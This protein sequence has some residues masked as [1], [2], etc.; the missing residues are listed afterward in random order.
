MQIHPAFQKIIRI[1]EI[2][3]T[4][5]L[6]TECRFQEQRKERY[7]LGSSLDKISCTLRTYVFVVGFTIVKELCH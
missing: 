5:G 3:V 2:Y 6:H 4:F 7:S 1:A